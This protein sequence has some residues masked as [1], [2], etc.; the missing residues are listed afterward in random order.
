VKSQAKKEGREEGVEKSVH[1]LKAYRQSTGKTTKRH[2]KNGC[3][4]KTST[5]KKTIRNCQKRKE[6]KTN[7]DGD[8]TQGR[9]GRG[10][11]NISSNLET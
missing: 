5:N 1:P 4:T 6:K 9:K 8:L 2:R 7:E 11:S 3:S 10:Q